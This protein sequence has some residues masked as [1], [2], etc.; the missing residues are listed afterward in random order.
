MQN[1]VNKSKNKSNKN[2]EYNLNCG[3]FSQLLK[4]VNKSNMGWRFDNI[5]SYVMGTTESFYSK[6][7]G[8]YGTAFVSL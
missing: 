4:T 1:K 8:H 2:S 3:H 7:M 5:L 6:G